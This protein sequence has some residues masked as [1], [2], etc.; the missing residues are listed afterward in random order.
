MKVL[1][2]LVITLSNGRTLTQSVRLDNMK[3][4]VEVQKEARAKKGVQAV[5]VGLK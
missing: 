2:V 5:C 1:L 3:K 4:C